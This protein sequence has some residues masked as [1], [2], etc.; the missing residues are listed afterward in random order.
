MNER[1]QTSSIVVYCWKS[2]S[3]RLSATSRTNWVVVQVGLATGVE[4]CLIQLEN[5]WCHVVLCEERALKCRTRYS[6]LVRDLGMS[7]ARW[8]LDN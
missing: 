8:A 4:S 7:R 5:S 6:G 1:S 3:V 2:M